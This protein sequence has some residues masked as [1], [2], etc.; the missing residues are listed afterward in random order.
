MSAIEIGLG[1]ELA[2]Y[3][4]MP[5]R[6]RIPALRAELATIDPAAHIDFLVGLPAVDEAREAADLGTPY[7]MCGDLYVLPGDH[8]RP[9]ALHALRANL[10]QAQATGTVDTIVMQV[11]GDRGRPTTAELVAFYREAYALAD[12]HGVRLDTE[13]HIDRWTYDPRRVVEVDRALRQE[14]GRGLTVCADF[15]HYV[16][17]IGNTQA[18]NWSAIAAAELVIDPN[19]VGDIVTTGIIAPGLVCSGHLRCAAPNDLP[20][21]QGSIQYPLGNPDADPR[22][23]TPVGSLKHYGAWR[24]ERTQAWQTMYQRTF[25]AHLATR[26][27]PVARFASE[28]IC[29]EDE[30]R[31]DAY[32]NVY[33]NLVAVAWACRAVHALSHPATYTA[34]G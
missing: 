34:K 12:A 7:R 17:Q 11:D 14:L 26:G 2:E 29:V 23:Q 13:T 5:L 6:Q 10:A 1:G 3:W 28:F 19:Q 31:M 9:P 16:H 27:A 20:R 24:A 15:S 22:Q 30:Y 8:R 4:S 32:R 18:S 21:G 33:Q 25:A